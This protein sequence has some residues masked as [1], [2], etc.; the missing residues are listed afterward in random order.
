M[1][2]GVEMII[3]IEPT[4]QC[5]I[6]SRGKTP[7]IRWLKEQIASGVTFADDRHRSGVRLLTDEQVREIRKAYVPYQV[8]QE[9][10]AQVYDVSRNTIQDL[11][12]GRSY[13]DV[14]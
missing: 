2:E 8:T 1:G 3:P 6:Y 5:K 11:I 4:R 13:R 7:Y 14:R 10:L 9:M 12:A